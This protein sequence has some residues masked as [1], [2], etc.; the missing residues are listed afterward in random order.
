MFSLPR[1]FMHGVH[2]TRSER[3][4]EPQVERTG[5]ATASALALIAAIVAW[6]V[7]SDTKRPPNASGSP[8]SCPS[9]GKGALV[10]NGSAPVDLKMAVEKADTCVAS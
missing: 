7:S 4:T 8:P 6:G 10:C 1:R 9:F 3:S 2:A 5:P